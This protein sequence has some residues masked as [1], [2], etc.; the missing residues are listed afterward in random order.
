MIFE[1]YRYI[2]ESLDEVNKEIYKIFHKDFFPKVS[3]VYKEGKR[4]RAAL[5]LFTSHA[6]DV[7]DINLI[8]TAAAVELVH[9][10]SLIHDDVVDE[11]DLRRDATS[12]NRLVGNHSAV[13]IGDYTFSTAIHWI[14]LTENPLLFK[15][16]S[17]AVV[18]MCE[19]EMIEEFTKREDT[20]DEDFYLD[21]IYKKT[22]ALFESASMLGSLYRG[23]NNEGFRE[24]G[25]KFGMLYQILDD[26]VDFLQGEDIIQ[27]KVTLPIIYTKDKIFRALPEFK[28]KKDDFNENKIKEIV[29]NNGGIERSVEKSKIFFSEVNNIVKNFSSPL[30]EFLRNFIEEVYEYAFGLINKFKEV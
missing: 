21:L 22:G 12:M 18:L 9:F 5:T 17:K 4:L 26:L 3:P 1:S 25:K 2:K 8:K 6:F 29:L 23:Q 14:S 16:I 7:Y 20:F 10:S 15:E 24:F 13:L 28:F 11:A 30:N 27:G 19:G